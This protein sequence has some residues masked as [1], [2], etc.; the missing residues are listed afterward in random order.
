M[1]KRSQ[2]ELFPVICKEVIGVKN[3]WFTCKLQLETEW[4]TTGGGRGLFHGDSTD[5]PPLRT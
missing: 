2:R 1:R 4:W 5:R 3:E